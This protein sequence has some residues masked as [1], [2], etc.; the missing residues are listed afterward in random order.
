MCQ[1][2]QRKKSLVWIS[3]LD[4]TLFQRVK[5]GIG[6]RGLGYQKKAK[7]KNLDIQIKGQSAVVL[8]TWEQK[9]KEKK[10]NG[11]VLSSAETD[12][13]QITNGIHGYIVVHELIV[14]EI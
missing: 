10:D 14:S 2:I 9:K 7:G 12:R 1:L 11:H 5:S 3:I 13:L 8:A 6:K 4:W